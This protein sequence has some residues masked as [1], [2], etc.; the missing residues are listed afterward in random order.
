MFGGGGYGE[1]KKRM[2]QMRENIKSRSNG[3]GL[4]LPGTVEPENSR[5]P[6]KWFKQESEIF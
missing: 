3:N 4:H 1:W 5:Q 6:L 2:S